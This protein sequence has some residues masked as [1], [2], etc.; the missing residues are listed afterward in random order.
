[1]TV[2]EIRAKIR[3]KTGCMTFAQDTPVG[4]AVGVPSSVRGVAHWSLVPIEDDSRGRF[5]DFMVSLNGT[6]PNAWLD[7]PEGA[8]ETP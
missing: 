8:R 6:V 3:A 5:V 4:V 2:E 7:R 1:M